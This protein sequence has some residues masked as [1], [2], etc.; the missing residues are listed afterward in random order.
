M[1]HEISH[2]TQRHL[3]RSLENA[4]N[5]TLASMAGVLAGILAG[6]AGGAVASVA[7]PVL[8]AVWT[9]DVARRLPYPL[10]RE[11]RSPLRRLAGPPSARAARRPGPDAGGSRLPRVVPCGGDRSRWSGR[12]ALADP[13]DAPSVELLVAQRR[14]G[15]QGDVAV[16]THGGRRASEPMPRSGVRFWRGA[17][18]LVVSPGVVGNE[19]AIVMLSDGSF[20]V[21]SGRQQ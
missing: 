10:P 13:V 2:V 14:A 7:Y 1:A 15:G 4:G 6:A 17:V 20:G 21:V 5:T 12:P 18:P 11:P 8:I 3:A 9:S 16:R 19:R